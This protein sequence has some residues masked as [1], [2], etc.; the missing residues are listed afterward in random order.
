MKIW[1]QSMTVLEHLPAYQARI[2]THA[3]KVL[4]PDT[5]L[6]LHG[7]APDT[8]PSNY[9][10]DDISYGALFAMHSLQWMGYAWKAQK[11]GFDA[12]AMCTMADPM[13]REVR[14]IVDMPVLGCA[15]V[16][17]H[18]APTLGRR[19]G[20]LLFIDRMGAFYEEKIRGYGLAERFVGA[21]PVGFG[22]N[23]VLAGFD[24]PGPLI[25]RFRAAAR[26]LIAAG[27]D[28]IIP[29]EVPMNLLLASEGID[30][31]ES[32][33]VMDSLGLTL[34]A[35]EAAVDR[36]EQPKRDGWHHARPHDE[37][38]E[39]VLRYYGLSRFMD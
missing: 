5:E 3:R 22:F 35:A 2:E 16:S 7:L 26:K 17:F 31:V 18:T 9:P 11:E 30:S 28:V 10:G 20:M 39:Q 4:R 15:E 38:V 13:L 37:R 23:D 1:H 14:A 27:A 29:A 25:D 24:R 32:A 12:F 8:Y 21:Q 6:V 19:F 36:G 33:V 34:K